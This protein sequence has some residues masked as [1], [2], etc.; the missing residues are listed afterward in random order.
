MNE[1]ELY[2]VKEYKFGNFL[3]TDIDSINDSC[4]RDCHNKYFPN[5]KYDCIYDSKLTN[6]TDKE[7]IN[8]TII[9][10]SMK[11]YDLNKKIKVARQNCFYIQSNKQTNKKNL[12]AFTIYKHKLLSEISNSDGS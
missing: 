9:G 12:F 2:V 11:L 8:L 1:N 10:K 6:I 3:T 7:I 5:F 4:F